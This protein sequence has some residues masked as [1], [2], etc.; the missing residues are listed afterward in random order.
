MKPGS[1]PEPAYGTGNTFGEFNL[2]AL[3]RLTHD[4][5]DDQSYM[6]VIT[7]KFIGYENLRRHSFVFRH[8]ES[9]VS[10]P[11]RIA[12]FCRPIQFEFDASS[13]V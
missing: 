7:Y 8:C 4:D 10:S 3:A 2:D 6:S 12:L 5:D 13:N 9:I 11:N 1:S